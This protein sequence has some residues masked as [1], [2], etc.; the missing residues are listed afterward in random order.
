MDGSWSSGTR[1]ERLALVDSLEL[2]SKHD[3]QVG[4]IK[5]DAS[6]ERFIVELLFVFL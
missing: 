4:M 2:I 5:Q 6:V 1:G 3:L